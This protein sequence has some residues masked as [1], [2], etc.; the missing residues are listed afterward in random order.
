M[1][2]GNTFAE[3]HSRKHTRKHICRNTF[4]FLILSAKN[5][6]KELRKPCSPKDHRKME[7][8]K[9]KLPPKLPWIWSENSISGNLDLHILRKFFLHTN[10][11][12]EFS[13]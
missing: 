4:E 1:Q 6:T 7:N 2:I 12:F 5:Q 8:F 3:T 13:Q 10:Y 11:L 9:Q